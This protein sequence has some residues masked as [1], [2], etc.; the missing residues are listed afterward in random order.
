MN[1]FL[2]IAAALLLCLAWVF[3]PSSPASDYANYVG[4]DGENGTD[5]LDPTNWTDNNPPLPDGSLHNVESGQTAVL[6][7]GTADVNAI[8]VG[9]ES[10]G[11]LTIDAGGVLNVIS[12]TSIWPHPSGF[13]TGLAIGGHRHNHTGNGT[14]NIINGGVVNV[15]R[16]PDAPAAEGRDVG[17]VGERADGLL[18][19]GAGSL[20]DSPQIVWRI[21]QFGGLYDSVY[22]ADGIVNI[23][24]TWNADIIFIGPNGGDAEN[25][26]VGKRHAV[27]GQGIRRAGL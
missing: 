8:Y 19:I 10:V 22:E 13:P 15:I 17:F 5:F 27:H 21:G 14:V 26:P 6:A 24:G 11:T 20:L 18:Y 9:D 4:F 16:D 3:V 23:E 1:R 2:L 25:K 12:E 7:G